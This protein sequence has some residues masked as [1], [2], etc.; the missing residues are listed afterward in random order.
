MS[1]RLLKVLTTFPG[2]DNT[3]RPITYNNSDMP[4][5]PHALVHRG[6]R[7]CTSQAVNDPFGFDCDTLLFD[8]IGADNGT[9]WE[10]NKETATL[11]KRLVSG[12]SNVAALPDPRPKPSPDGNRVGRMPLTDFVVHNWDVM[13]YGPMK[14]G[15]PPQELQMDIDTGSADLWVR[16][17]SLNPGYT[18]LRGLGASKLYQLWH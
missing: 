11:A 9:Q 13:Y 4:S 15:F 5:D 6:K 3:T 12:A 2:A 1:A 16:P 7:R 10:E 8:R 14:F 18:H 17:T